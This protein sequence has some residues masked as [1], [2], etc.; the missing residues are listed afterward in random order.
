MN[1]QTTNIVLT[2]VNLIWGITIVWGIWK[3]L[4]GRNSTE[5]AFFVGEVQPALLEAKD[6]ALHHG[7]EI[8]HVAL[9]NNNNPKAPKQFT[10]I[11]T[12]KTK[13]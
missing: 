8:S 4:R 11:V 1:Q 12:Y 3:A 2:I 9:A 7:F 5:V 10:L 13:S 6:Y